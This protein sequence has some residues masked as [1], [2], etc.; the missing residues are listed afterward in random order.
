[1]A[2]FI[3]EN[4][5]FA[6]H[7][8]IS[9]MMPLMKNIYPAFVL[10]TFFLF[11]GCNK[12]TGPSQAEKDRTEIEQ[13]AKNNNLNGS[14]TESGLYYVITNA[15]SDE[16]PNA[17]SNITIAYKGF[18]LSGT[19]FDQRDYVTF[20]LSDLIKGWQEGVPL[21]GKGGEITLLIPSHLAYNDGVRAF[22]IKL[23]QFSK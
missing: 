16:H 8:L 6:G 22:D 3:V 10:I 4:L 12:D 7:K 15:G 14:F 2:S 17:S 1:V 18:Y 19:V 5:I 23:F 21:I 13:Y 20:N 11:G 9:L